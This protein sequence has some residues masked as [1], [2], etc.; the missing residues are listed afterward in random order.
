[1]FKKILASVLCC[2]SLLSFTG[3]N[4]EEDW[5]TATPDGEIQSIL[6]DDAII[7]TE[8][9]FEEVVGLMRT[10]P[11]DYEGR[12]ISLSGYC[13]YV[14]QQYMIYCPSDAEAAVDGRMFLRYVLDESKVENENDYI[15]KY[16]SI[17]GTFVVKDIKGEEA[18]RYF[19]LDVEDIVIDN[20]AYYVEDDT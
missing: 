7:I 6:R 16:C 20:S 17:I 3:C 11:L 2:V 4:N 12:Q 14:N 19:Y 5:Q 13:D 15:A 10:N 18:T 9:N 8:D 1:M